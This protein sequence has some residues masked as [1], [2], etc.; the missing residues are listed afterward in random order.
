MEQTNNKRFKRI[1]NL[2][3]LKNLIVLIVVLMLFCSTPIINSKQTVYK[4]SN[5]EVVSWILNITF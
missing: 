5:I 3:N 2:F 4:A 1:K